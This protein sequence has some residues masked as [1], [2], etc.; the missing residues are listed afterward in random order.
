MV[1]PAEICELIEALRREVAELRRENEALRADNAALRAEVAE[2]RRQLGMDSSNSSKPPL[3]DGL[4]KKSR[5]PG[6]LRGRS[7]KKSGG[8]AGHKG[9]TLRQA[10]APDRVVRH[11]AQACSRCRADLTAAMQTGVEKRQVFDLPERLIEVAEHQARSIA[12]RRAAGRRKPS[13]LRAS[14]RR[15]NTASVFE[16]RRFISTSISSFPRMKLPKR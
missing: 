16:R 1:L 6:S 14:P 3:S 2:L 10:E 7:G 13:F 9:D 11:E 5:I 12:V 15:R 8:Q 4:K